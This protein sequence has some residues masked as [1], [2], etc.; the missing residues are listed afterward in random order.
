M[1]AQQQAERLA[2]LYAT[3][4][5]SQS[6]G[7]LGYAEG[8]STIKEARNL[9][10]Q[11]VPERRGRLVKTAEDS[12]VASFPT[13]LDAVKAAI[14]IERAAVENR[15]KK[16][17]LNIRIFIHSGEEAQGAGSLQ[18]ELSEFMT[19]TAGITKPGHIYVSTDACT[20]SQALNAV[21]FKPLGEPLRQGQTPYY[22]LT[23]RPETD[24][25]PGG[26][27]SA[28]A[29]KRAAG[30]R[31]TGT[32]VHGAA[33]LTGPNAPCFY[34]GSGRHKSTACPS[35]QLPYATNGLARLG[36]LSMDGINRLFS[37]YLSEAGDDLPVMAEPV[38]KDENL[39]YL[40]PWAFYEL[41]RVFQL[42]FLDIVWNALPKEDW[43][44]ARESKREGSQEGGLLWLARDCIRT[45]RLEEAED[46]L[47]RY[48]NKKTSTDYRTLCGFAFI[49]IEKENY[50]TAG[51]FVIEA[52]NQP[53]TLL[54]KTYLL[55]LLSRIYEFIGDTGKS[56]DRLRDA[57]SMEPFCPEAI[58]EQ[59]IRQFRGRR[60]TDATNRLVKL[61]HSYREYYTAALIAPELTKFQGLIGPEL[62][63]MVEKARE[64]AQVAT[65]EAERAV[66]VLR[67]F[68]GEEDAD[69]AEVLSY[70]QEM[71]DLIEGP[72]A[73]Y[74]YSDATVIGQ[75]ITARCG[76]IEE[77]RAKQAA[78]VIRKLE[79]RIGE[80]VRDTTQPKKAK[81]L[82]Q[83]VVDRIARLKEDLQAR[84]A[85]GPCLVEC[86]ETTQELEGI[87]ETIKAMDASHAFFMM[88]ARFSKDLALAF[89]ITA[90]L[91]FVVF[92]GCINLLG[93]VRP[94]FTVLKPAE[95]WGAQKAIILAGFLFA[96]MFAGFRA[97]ML[98]H[99]P[100][101]EE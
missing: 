79:I 72:E 6:P 36:H 76:E 3:I 26:T 67:N 24:C 59:V 4:S 30:G 70:H 9:V 85:I 23:W 8:I 33:L 54:Q 35:K 48:D 41:K 93:A 83:H 43:Y 60:E 11:T 31:S 42:R 2:V 45:S 18:A 98:K 75:Q 62:E 12:V 74:N 38:S 49:K 22:D 71:Q 15:D 14:V 55:I 5:A 69:V 13:A 50:I 92:P 66:T 89:F 80:M 28:Q 81:A 78:K 64:D 20:N 65:G 86:E 34:C 37:D 47:K 39:T 10:V 32:F 29:L 97:F 19:R 21:E 17:P 16:A 46:L 7:H 101:R 87:M 68:A 25:T 90:A 1:E 99:N 77:E 44:K 61:I 27:V 95:V 94:E 100:Q 82:L 52:L 88:W 56:D 96:L 84:A 63:K 73:L 57:L 53:T 58:F 51:D 91:G 40:A